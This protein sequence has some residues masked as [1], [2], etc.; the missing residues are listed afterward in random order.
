MGTPSKEDI[1]VCVECKKK[2]SDPNDRLL[3][4]D[5]CDERHCTKCLAIT[6]AQYTFLTKSATM[7]FCVN[8]MPKVRETIKVEKEIEEKCNAHYAKFQKRCDEIDERCKNIESQV[9]GKVSKTDI[10]Q[11]I[12]DKIN[13]AI[14]G[15]K[16]E[17][18]TANPV[19]NNNEIK[20][21]VEDVVGD[22]IAEN[23]K[24]IS[25][26]KSRE[27]NLVLFNLPEPET[28][29]I[30]ERIKADAEVVTKMIEYLNIE[31]IDGIEVEEATRLGA[32][33][34]NPK[35]NPRASIIKFKTIEAKK[36]ILTNA[37]KLANSNNDILKNIKINN[38][39]SKKDRETEKELLKKKAAKNLEE[40][41]PFKHV[42]RGP[43]GERRIVRI[44]NN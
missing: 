2:F 5:F 18:A 36:T 39:L 8:C 16:I 3:E 35:E 9:E 41:G 4:C 25:N 14:E 34:E 37:H 6:P 38:D 24:E 30:N 21:M 40:Q 26:R 22:K 28:N 29:S 20:Q 1:W 7:W 32:R 23:E 44:R 19:N 43:P 11:L 15:G 27:R 33:K 10:D 31:T 17:Q 12:S 42:I 13:E